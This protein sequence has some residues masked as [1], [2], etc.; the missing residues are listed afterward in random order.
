METDQVNGAVVLKRGRI[1]PVQRRH[2]WV[3]SGA[4]D[5]V[6]GD[7]ADGDIVDVRDAGRNFLARG[8]INRHSQIMV[9]ILTWREEEAVDARFWRER[10]QVALAARS[11]LAASAGTTAYRVVHG[12]SDFLPG[13]IVD[14]YDDWVAVQFLTLGVALRQE[15]IIDA[16][17][18]LLSPRGIYERSDV[19]VRS[20]EGLGQ[21]SGVLWGEEPPDLVTILENG[22]GFLADV[23]HGH[24]TG[25]YLDQRENRSLMSFFCGGADVL[26]AFAYSGAFSVYA[27]AAGA[28][29]LTLVDSSARALDLAGRNLVLNG[30]SDREVALIEGDVFSVLRGFRSQERL[31]DVIVLDPPKFAHTGREVRR[32]SRAY[33]DVNLL[34]FQLLRS[35]G[36]LVTFSC[37]GGVSRDLFQKIVSGAAL[38][39]GRDV[40]IVR[41]LSQS[42]DHPVSLSFPEGAYLKG[43]VLRIV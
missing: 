2:P 35:G 39:A 20:K 15:P 12:E 18:D 34:A 40:Q 28:K 33:K 38:D 5:R 36:T 16:L 3:F 14:R 9:R 8:Y 1:R 10:I 13:L 21:K 41:V 42:F 43:L 24:K 30:F 26:D 22:W 6:E 11:A 27:S 17:A 7:P 29:S 32:A 25:F 37:S 31:F 23:R 19:D 4:V